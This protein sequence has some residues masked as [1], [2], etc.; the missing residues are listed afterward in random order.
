MYL[1]GQ[2]DM[3]WHDVEYNGETVCTQFRWGNNVMGWQG[4]MA[5]LSYAQAVTP[6]LSLGAEAG[7]M[8]DFSTPTASMSF[9]YD[10]PSEAWMGI[11]KSHAQPAA[12]NEG[13]VREFTMHY[14]RKVMKDRLNLGTSLT[15]I[16]AAMH[17]SCAVGAEIRLHQSTVATTFS[18]STNKL[19]TTIDVKLQPTINFKLSAEAVFGG[20]NQQTGEKS[21]SYRFGYGLSV[22]C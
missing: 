16:P 7:L 18:P 8:N 2:N 17:T 11:T 22:G 21:D 12:A 10:V 14:H 15:F 1:T 13:G 19:S 9:K 6:A 20:V 5:Q 4:K 3:F